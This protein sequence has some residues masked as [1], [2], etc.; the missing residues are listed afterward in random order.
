VSNHISEN[1]QLTESKTTEYIWYGDKVQYEEV[2]QNNTV[3]PKVNMWGMSGIAARNNELFSS[4]AHGNTDA[5]YDGT[6][7]VKRYTY[8]AYGNA[9]SD[10]GED[11]NPYRYCGESYDEETGL[12]YLRARYY[13]PSIGR[14]MSEDPAQD[15]LNWYVYCG[16]NPVMYIDPLGLYSLQYDEDGRVYAV[17]DLKA[18]DTLYKIAE[19]EVGDGNSWRK[20]NYPFDPCYLGNGQWVDITGIYN[21]KYPNPNPNVPYIGSA[22]YEAGVRLSY[23]NGNF[24]YDVSIPFNNAMWNAG[25]EAKNHKLNVEWFIGKVNHG[26]DWDIKRSAP[27]EKTI[28]ITYPGSMDSQV[29]VFD[30]VYTP[31]QLGNIMYG[32]TASAAGF[33][34]TITYAGSVYAAGALDKNEFNDWPYIME[35]I[36]WY[37]GF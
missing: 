2:T 16:N 9:I 13:D 20:M 8:D 17:I 7:T 4:D 33:S 24:Y 32:Y 34:M 6:T 37:N 12:Y 3:T 10:N 29:V 26:K 21:D 35:G 18:G 15:G 11:D 5:S 23:K 28:G 14:F 31:E 27:W 30:E 36:R 1:G 25:Q 22:D 19:S